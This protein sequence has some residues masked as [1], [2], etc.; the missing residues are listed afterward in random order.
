M[1]RRKSQRI[2]IPEFDLDEPDDYYTFYVMILGISE[3]LFWYA[4]WS[5]VRDVAENKRAWDA[6]LSNEQERLMDKK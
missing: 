2:R 3:E 1:T 5:F 6:W 4:D